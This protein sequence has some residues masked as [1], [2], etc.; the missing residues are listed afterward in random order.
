MEREYRVSRWPELSHPSSVCRVLFEHSSRSSTTPAPQ[1]GP[2]LAEKNREPSSPPSLTFP[3]AWIIPN[4]HSLWVMVN[5]NGSGCSGRLEGL[6][7]PGMKE[8]RAGFE[9]QRSWPLSRPA[10]PVPTG[11]ILHRLPQNPPLWGIPLCFPEG[12]GS[13]DFV[14]PGRSPRVA[15]P[16]PPAAT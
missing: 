13:Q 1:D 10:R 4:K 3:R 12:A 9:G 14:P 5:F 16:Q 11:N 15:L 2:Y 7:V 6:I 8:I